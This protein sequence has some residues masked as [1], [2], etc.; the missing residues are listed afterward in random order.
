MLCGHFGVCEP[1]FAVSTAHSVLPACTARACTA[2][3]RADALHAVCYGPR[4]SRSTTAARRS[5]R[6]EQR[7]VSAESAKTAITQAMLLRCRAISSTQPS[8]PAAEDDGAKLSHKYTSQ[9][10]VNAVTK[11]D[12]IVRTRETLSNRCAGADSAMWETMQQEARAAAEEEPLLASFMFATVLNHR[13]LQSALAFHLAN[14][15][16][17]NAI[18]ATQLM[19]LFTD[20]MAG[21][22]GDVIATEIQQDLL[23]VV[24]RDPACNKFIDCLCYYKGFLALEAHRIAHALWKA[25]RVAVA[26]HLQ[27]QVSK[28]LQVDIH[29]AAV[30][31]PGA[32]L[33][34]ATGV[35][36]G[37]TARIGKN[38]S[39][40]HHVTLGGSGKK[41][42]VRHPQIGDGVLIGAGAT[43][44]GNV[45]VGEGAQIGA[46]SLVLENV[47]A[48]ST[49]VGVPAKVVL[50]GDKTASQV[51]PALDMKHERCI[52][53]QA[54]AANG[55]DKQSH[56]KIDQ[57]NHAPAPDTMFASALRHD[58]PQIHS[59][60]NGK[61]PA[62]SEVSSPDI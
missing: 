18:P 34:H 27:S 12:Y 20:F 61:P 35:V 60:D 46:C 2:H 24:E 15:L 31:G 22:D 30:I 13:S 56:R 50:R 9:K 17:S 28:A 39:M 62:A 40:L 33:D 41:H 51:V 3:A 36:I 57:V 5:G 4:L 26:Y 48:H 29:P 32:F 25:G 49:V 21:E 52:E 6:L 42:G 53:N 54:D 55:T 43:L 19:R 38:V 7:R 23:A 37:E 14:K 1:A 58:A 10:S 16:A 59:D 44:L 11:P 8:P 47:P 45:S